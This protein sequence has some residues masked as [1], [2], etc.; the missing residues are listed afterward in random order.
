MELRDFLA[1]PHRFRW[2]G[3]DGDD[4]MTWCASWIREC[5]GVDPAAAVRGTYSTEEGAHRLLASRGGLVAY[6]DS[7]LL[8]LGFTRT[9]SPKVGDVG[10]VSTTTPTGTTQSAAINFSK[11]WAMLSPG[12]V[13]A[14]RADLVAAWRFPV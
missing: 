3:V 5:I 11:T 4:C 10:V 1:L 13:V 2:G 9:D 14:K 6:A 8:P 12:R 7:Q